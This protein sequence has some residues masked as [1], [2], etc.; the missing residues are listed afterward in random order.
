MIKYDKLLNLNTYEEYFD[1]KCPSCKSDGMKKGTF[2]LI[3]TGIPYK[4][5]LI[6]NSDIK[7]KTV[8]K[9]YDSLPY[10]KEALLMALQKD[11]HNIVVQCNVCK[12][13]SG[14]YDNIKS[15]DMKKWITRNLP[16]FL[17]LRS[18]K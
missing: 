17:D 2:N 7:N 16:F 3:P 13:R 15:S 4:P 8:R 12:N 18:K 6:D 5:D 11:S 10:L 9:Y 14:V 1:F